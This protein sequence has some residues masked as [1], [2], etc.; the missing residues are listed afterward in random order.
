MNNVLVITNHESLLLDK[1]RQLE[2]DVFVLEEKTNIQFDN[3]ST[4]V[5][6]SVLSKSEKKELLKQLPKSCDVYSDL[7]CTDPNE[8]YAEFRSLGGCFST[9]FLTP[10]NKFECHIKKVSEAVYSIFEQLELQAVML[11][12]P[13]IGFVYP[14]T[15]AQIVNEAY[16]ALEESVASKEDIDRAMRF[17]VNYPHGPFEWSA[18]REQYF[19]WILDELYEKLHD[20]RYRVCPLFRA[21]S[22]E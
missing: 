3:Y 13:T 19:V 22:Q 8:F 9:T 20:D 5:D 4:V 2:C 7:S 14:R 6:F 10:T 21:Q 12:E 15:V 17:G 1:I 11:S 16:F 18:S